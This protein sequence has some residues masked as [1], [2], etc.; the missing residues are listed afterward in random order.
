M[1]R[2]TLLYILLILCSILA[3]SNIGIA[4]AQDT[5]Y[6]RADGTVE[7]TDKIHRDGDVFT[8]RGNVSVGIQV[9]RSNII[10]DGAWCTLQGDGEIH[11]PTDVRGMGLEIV[12]C[13]NV[14]IRNLN[15]REF[16][17]GIRFTNSSDCTVR[18]NVLEDNS[19]GVEMGYI[20]GIYS[21]NNTISG[22]I[23][24]RNRN[25][26]IRLISGSSNTISG[27]IITENDV[28]VS[29]W[30]TSGNYVVWNNITGNDEGIY[31]ET[32]GINL[33]H[34]NN[35]VDNT[36]DYW[37]YGY[38][39]WPFQLPFSEN[40]WDDGSEGNYWDEYT[41]KDD[42]G[43]GIGDTPYILYK[44]N[45]DTSPLMQ[46]TEVPITIPEYP[47]WLPILIL[48]VGITVVVAVYASKKNH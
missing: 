27:N 36:K 40:N 47:S 38:T 1:N 32:S 42:N 33:I 11:G 37:D 35:F 24:K 16:T 43:D 12:E 2:F 39:P 20:D 34:H 17:R 7:G 31:F 28:G 4:K 18:H 15:I 14:T 30:G 10:V 44:N 5:I 45:T 23:I 25:A 22:N 26:G 29:I 6:I 19:I 48:M 41:G 9:R 3:F 13:T 46:P 8:F 21:Y